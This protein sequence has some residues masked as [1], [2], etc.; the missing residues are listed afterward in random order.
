MD[1]VKIRTFN[2]PLDIKMHRTIENICGV[3]DGHEECWTLT[4]VLHY[5]DVRINIDVRFARTRLEA[6]RLL[7]KKL[8]TLHDAI[9]MLRNEA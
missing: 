3:T 8:Y 2:P 1:Y 5:E 7:R 4:S 6:L 9:C